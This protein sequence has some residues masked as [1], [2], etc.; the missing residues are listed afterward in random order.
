MSCV[1]NAGSSFI[2]FCIQIRARY[3]LT[4]NAALATRLSVSALP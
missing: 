4:W 3:F 2:K 1:C